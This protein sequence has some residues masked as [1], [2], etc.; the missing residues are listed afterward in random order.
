MASLFRFC[1]PHQFLNIFDRKGSAFI[2]WFLFPTGRVFNKKI[3][4]LLAALIIS[5][6]VLPC[7][8]KSPSAH[9]AQEKPKVTDSGS[10]FL[11]AFAKD[12]VG[13]LRDVEGRVFEG[14]QFICECSTKAIGRRDESF[15]ASTPPNNDTS[16]QS[17]KENRECREEKFFNHMLFLSVIVSVIIIVVGITSNYTEEARVIWDI[18]EE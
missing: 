11:E 3:C 12:V 15:S 16:E 10:V 8:V 7:A 14:R 5:V 18:P 9:A 13:V 2:N 6:V 4:W 1:K 17:C